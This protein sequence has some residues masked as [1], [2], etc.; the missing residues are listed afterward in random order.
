MIGGCWIWKAK[1][2]RSGYPAL[3]EDTWG[4]S[5][6]RQWIYQASGYTLQ[7][8]KTLYSSCENRL[9]CNPEHL[10]YENKSP[11]L[12]EFMESVSM[13]SAETKEGWGKCWLWIGACGK[14]FG[15]NLVGHGRLSKSRWGE[16][17]A[18][19][20]IYKT[21]YPSEDISSSTI[22]HRC[23]VAN[24][25]NPKHLYKGDQIQNMSDM[26]Q[27][28]RGHSQ[29][30][31]SKEHALAIRKRIVSG[32]KTKDLCQ[33]LNCSK[34]CIADLKKGRSW[35]EKECFPADWPF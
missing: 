34:V 29:V 21:T 25:V 19:R 20:W 27:Q 5:Y 2:L 33:E 4:H 23:D 26:K 1:S 17:L 12:A 30:I 13:N 18:H 22:N 15:S 24:C 28:G 14:P 8:N 7:P 35:K 16:S 3:N 10:S 31:K 32:A 11:L 6:A 9:C